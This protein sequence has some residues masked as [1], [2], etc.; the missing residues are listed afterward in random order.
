MLRRKSANHVDP[1]ASFM[2]LA[3]KLY[4]NGEPIPELDGTGIP[5]YT[6]SDDDLE[7]QLLHPQPA[8]PTS[9]TDVDTNSTTQPAKMTWWNNYNINQ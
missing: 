2:E 8:V 6:E 9:E 1:F 3:A 5:D 4:K 7:E